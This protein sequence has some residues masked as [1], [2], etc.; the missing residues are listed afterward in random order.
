MVNQTM[1]Q[2]TRTLT[3]LATT[4][5]LLLIATAFAVPATATEDAEAPCQ[6]D[7]DEAQQYA[8]EHDVCTD[9]YMEMVCPHDS[10]VTYSAPN[11][12][13]ISVLQER[14][15]TDVQKQSLWERIITALRSLLPF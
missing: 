6:Q 4:A 13:E 8:A 3:V 1:K 15:W 10:S 14:G 11:G 9:Q 5:L 12:C 7:I 2:P